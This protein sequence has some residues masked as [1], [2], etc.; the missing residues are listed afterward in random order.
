MNVCAELSHNT[1][2]MPISSVARMMTPY[3]IML[4]GM[5]IVSSDNYVRA[6]ERCPAG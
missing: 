2:A 4:V 5:A 3:R 1:S 6:G